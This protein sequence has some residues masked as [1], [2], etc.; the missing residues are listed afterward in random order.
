MIF[1]EDILGKLAIVYH[2]SHSDN[3]ISSVKAKGYNPG[4]GDMY[5]R[6]F[7]ATYDLDS[8]LRAD[9]QDSYGDHV[10][11]FA[12]D[13]SKYFFFDYSEFEKTPLFREYNKKYPGNPINETNFIRFQFQYFNIMDKPNYKEYSSKESFNAAKKEY[14]DKLHKSAN[15]IQKKSQKNYTSDA[16]EYTYGVY[17][18]YNFTEKVKGIVFTGRHDGR[19]LVAYDTSTIKPL[20]EVE[21]ELEAKWYY[22]IE[23]SI[24]VENEGEY[25]ELTFFAS[26]VRFNDDGDYETEENADET[27]SSLVK[28]YPIGEGYDMTSPELI[29]LK[30]I[31]EFNIMNGV[32]MYIKYEDITPEQA[33]DNAWNL[34]RGQID[35]NDT[36]YED[37]EPKREVY[38]AFNNK[39]I[40]QYIILDEGNEIDAFTKEIIDK[41]VTFSYSYT[42]EE[43]Y[44][45]LDGATY[46]IYSARD[47]DSSPSNELWRG[48]P[49]DPNY[50]Q[51]P[52]VSYHPSQMKF[53]FG[54]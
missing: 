15:I 22:Q 47:Y 11:K 1:N 31:S 41:S 14:L 32:G 28:I 45:S 36:N 29:K 51:P 12:V 24:Q 39:E 6:G 44:T 25:L 49:N 46:N 43:E 54:A 20:S 3:L 13:T 17:S 23:E 8:Q 5:G 50:V 9:M 53:D 21:V 38:K 34:W 16:A 48:N 27:T 19:V 10:Y 2:R 26:L 4:S 52:Y 7:Y 33:Q 37:Y 35:I 18:L 40:V 30:Y 42:S